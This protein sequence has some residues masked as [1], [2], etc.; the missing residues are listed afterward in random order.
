M[1]ENQ[2]QAMKINKVK[3]T[4]HIEDPKVDGTRI[5][6]GNSKWK[7]PKLGSKKTTDLS[8]TVETG[9]GSIF[10]KVSQNQRKSVKEN[11]IN[12]SLISLGLAVANANDRDLYQVTDINYLISHVRNDFALYNKIR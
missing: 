6:F 9:L 11:T 12:N 8:S 2:F 3:D 5:R 1:Q 7:F 4:N 10:T